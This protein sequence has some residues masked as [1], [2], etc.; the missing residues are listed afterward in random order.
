[1]EEECEDIS[2]RINGD[3]VKFEDLPEDIRNIAQIRKIEQPNN[4]CNNYNLNLI[5]SL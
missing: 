5:F 4:G 1:M 2:S 3:Y